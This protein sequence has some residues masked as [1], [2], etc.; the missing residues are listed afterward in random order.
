[1]IFLLSLTIC[2][3]LSKKRFKSKVMITFDQHRQGVI[4]DLAALV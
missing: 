3:D 1:M 4:A 2:T